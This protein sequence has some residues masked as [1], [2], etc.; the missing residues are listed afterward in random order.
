[1][2]LAQ[3]IA[4]GVWPGFGAA[5]EGREPARRWPTPAPTPAPRVGRTTRDPNRHE[6]VI[7]YIEKHGPVRVADL[8]L[9]LGIN[10]GNASVTLSNMRAQGLL[11]RPRS[12]EYELP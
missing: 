10:R 8:A 1:M 3:A 4:A 2:N 9:G 5:G 11:K 6:Q 7:A 12:G